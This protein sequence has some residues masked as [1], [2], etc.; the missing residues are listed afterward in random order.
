[1]GTT[2]IIVQVRRALGGINQCNLML[3]NKTNY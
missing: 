1:M 2:S 3:E